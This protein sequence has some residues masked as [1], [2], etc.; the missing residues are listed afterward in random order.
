T[1]REGTRYCRDGVF[2][3]CEDVHSFAAPA[4]AITALI[5]QNLAPARCSDCDPNCF[6]VRDDLDP[7][8][9]PLGSVASGLGYDGSGSGLS[10]TPAGALPG[11][12]APAGIPAG[13]LV[14]TIPAGMTASTSYAARVRPARSDVYL[15]LDQSLSMAEETAWI[16]DRF[17]TGTF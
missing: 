13:A 1:C 6:R 2:G 8:R 11:T 7:A 12:G 14:L 15:L 5:D 17:D 10:L 3:D 16:S 4:P 9:G